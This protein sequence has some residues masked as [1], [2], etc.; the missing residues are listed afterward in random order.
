MPEDDKKKKAAEQKL[1]DEL[2]EKA[3]IFEGG[4][5]IR[6]GEKQ[7]IPEE[8]DFIKEFLEKLQRGEKIT[9]SGPIPED[10]NPPESKD[11]LQDEIMREVLEQIKKKRLN[12]KVR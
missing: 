2:F 5:E 4:V 6:P 1:L 3:P 11:K 12:N 10:P 8:F 7:E 9:P